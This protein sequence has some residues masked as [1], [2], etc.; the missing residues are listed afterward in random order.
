M[1]PRDPMF[2]TNFFTT[3][4]ARCETPEPEPEDRK[5]A[6]IVAFIKCVNSTILA[7]VNYQE[8]IIYEQYEPLFAGAIK[9]LR[10]CGQT[11]DDPK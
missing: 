7:H 1:I 11:N 2:F 8:E 6:V 9:K 5:S 4:L 3:F 10:K